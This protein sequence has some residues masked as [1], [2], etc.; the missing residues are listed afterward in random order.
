MP[1]GKTKTPTSFMDLMKEVCRSILNCSIIVYVDN[2][3]V[4]SKTKEQHE[5]HMQ[6]ILGS[7]RKERLQTKFSKCNFQFR[8]VLFM[9]H[10]VIQNGVLL[11]LAKIKVMTQ[12]EVLKST[13]MIQRYLGLGRHYMRFIMNFSKIFVP[14]TPLKKKKVDFHCGHELQ[15]VYETL[16]QKLYEDPVL[17]LP[18]RVED[19]VVR[20][21][22]SITG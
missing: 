9:G 19:F 4:Y 22:A 6:E 16:R 7:M 3:L 15:A 12:W 11:Y 13:S 20:C 17:T 21:D 14:I 10:L 8:K 2:I 1:F 5:K 18:Q